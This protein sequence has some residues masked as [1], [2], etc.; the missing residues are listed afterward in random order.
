MKDNFDPIAFAK[1]SAVEA[2]DQRNDPSYGGSIGRAAQTY[3]VNVRDT[4]SEYNALEHLDDAIVHFCQEVALLSPKVHLVVYMKLAE[5]SNQYHTAVF[6]NLVD[7]QLWWDSIH[8][9][10]KQYM[11]NAPRPR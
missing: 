11:I 10:R 2:W 1:A 6:D 4:L 8:Y 7:A 5:P 9:L 3:I